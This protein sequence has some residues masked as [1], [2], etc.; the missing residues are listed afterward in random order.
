[1]S[2]P[3]KIHYCWFGKTPLPKQAVQCMESWKRYCP[4][5][6]IIRWDESNYSISKNEYMNQAYKVKKWGFVPD[7]A[8]LDIIYQHGGIY[9]DTDVELIKCLDT[10]LQNKAFMGFESADRVNLGQGFG[11]E[12][13]HPL[14]K[15][16]LE[17]YDT[18]K[19]IDKEG[20]MNLTVSP[21]YQTAI[22]ENHNLKKD[23]SEQFIE[24]VHI[25]PSDFFCPKSLETG[26][27][28]ITDNTYS[29]HHFDASWMPLKN[30]FHMRVAQILGPEN[31]KRIKRILGRG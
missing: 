25:F 9:L 12:A 29:I 22:L 30:K 31:T 1:M 3:K 20:E 4:D 11:A 2:I 13:G 26:K 17:M 14:I 16:M 8:R 7:Y 23:N 19:F 6:Q 10:L 27:I 5:F 18:L 28:Q 24:N 21:Y 15:E